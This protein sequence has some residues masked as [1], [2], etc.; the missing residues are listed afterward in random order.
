MSS[1]IH[2]RNWIASAISSTGSG[3]GLVAQIGDDVANAR[4]H[5]LPILHADAD[6]G[7]NAFERLDDLR[8]LRRILRAFDMKVDEAFALAADR[9]RALEVDE[10][11][12]EVALD[13][14]YRMNEQADIEAAL[15]EFGRPRN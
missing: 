1:A 8:P 9:A 12:G 11:A 6:I 15:I 13:D 7:E 3:G 5:R 14:E 4:Q 2:S 10:P